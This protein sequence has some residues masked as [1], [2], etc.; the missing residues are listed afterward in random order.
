MLAS[1]HEA[2]GKAICQWELSMQRLCLHAQ[3]F[4]TG[5]AETA[6]SVAYDAPS[7]KLLAFLRKHFGAPACLRL[8]AAGMHCFSTGADG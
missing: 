1:M 3:A 4:L 8:P 7:T 6:S 5:Q 2:P